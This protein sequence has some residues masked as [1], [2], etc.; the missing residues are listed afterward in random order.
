MQLLEVP[1]IKKGNSPIYSTNTKNK[2][3]HFKYIIILTMVDIMKTN[4]LS[5]LRFVSLCLIV[6][7]SSCSYTKE[8]INSFIPDTLLENIELKSE[9]WVLRIKEITDG[10]NQIQQAKGHLK[11]L[12]D[13]MRLI[14]VKFDLKNITSTK[15]FY[16]IKKI[17]LENAKAKGEIVYAKVGNVLNFSSPSQRYRP[18]IEQNDSVTRELAFIFPKNEMPTKV[19]FPDIGET[20]IYKTAQ[21]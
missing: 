7:V 1:S 21:N 17:V 5:H 16:D 2:N 20:T 11:P 4:F 10:P 8:F 15:Q 13:D 6:C 18:E 19:V 9:A 14:W 3:G 12:S